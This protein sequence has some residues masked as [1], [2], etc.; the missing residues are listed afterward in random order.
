MPNYPN[1]YQRYDSKGDLTT[2]QPA[3]LLTAE[4]LPAVSRQAEI[5]QQK[6]EIGKQI[7][8]IGLKLD[9]GIMS[10]RKTVAEV[11]SADAIADIHQRAMRRA[12]ARLPFEILFV[13]ERV[14]RHNRPLPAVRSMRPT[15][16]V[17]LASQENLAA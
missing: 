17:A 11:N 6:G 14:G 4:T 15:N 8:D 16:A 13:V 9:A 10:T 7:A 3:H 12:M 2:Q 1:T 5:T